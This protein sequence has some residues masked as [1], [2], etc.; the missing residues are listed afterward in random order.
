MIVS[1]LTHRLAGLATLLA[2]VGLAPAVSA[3]VTV[4]EEDFEDETVAYTTSID[5]YSDD[6]G[7]F[8]TRTDGSNIS[9]SYEVTGFGGSSY[10]AAQDIDDGGAFEPTQSMSFMGLDVEGLTDLQVSFRLAEDQASN[11]DEDW[12]AADYFRVYATVYD[13]AVAGRQRNS[14]VLV[15]A[16][17]AEEPEEDQF[18]NRPLVDTD[19][20]GIGDGTEITPEFAAFMASIPGTGERLDLRIEFSL[21]AGDVDIALDDV[22][23]TGTQ[24]EVEPLACAVGTGMTFVS[25][26]LDTDGNGVNG[27]QVIVFNEGP[28]DVLLEACDFAVVDPFTEQ[29]TFVKGLPSQ[30]VL[31]AGTAAG[32]NTT[33]FGFPDDTLPDGPGAVVLIEGTPAVGATVADLLPNLI[34]G[35]VY[36]SETEIVGIYSSSATATTSA[37]D[38]L[39]ALASLSRSV[40]NEDVVNGIDMAVTAA[41]NPLRDRTTVTFGVAEAADVRVAVYDALG[42]EVALLADAP[43]AA[44]RH[45]VTFEAA[46]LPAGVYVIRAVVGADARIARVTL[47]R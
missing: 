10:F 21:N 23:V 41:P 12:D 19:L 24:E 1:T 35:L 32:L 43:Y 15:F 16:V 36:V 42:R 34:T 44:G 2:F 8:F 25:D 29:V 20:N 22:M 3:Q 6:F 31:Q 17:E 18:N 13:E 45:D 26:E 7:D 39:A 11:D 47:A 33:F 9:T 28:G 4:L 5:E 37:E 14:E 27:E 30:Q 46:D 38:F 40:A